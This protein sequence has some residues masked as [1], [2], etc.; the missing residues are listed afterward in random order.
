[1][2]INSYKVGAGT[3]TLGDADLA[4]AAQC[5]SAAVVPSESVK[6][7]EP[8]PVLSGEELPGASSATISARFKGKF[9]Q[10]GNTTGVVAFTYENAGELVPFTYVPNTGESASVEGFVRIVPL[11]IGADVSKTDRAEADFDWAAYAADDESGIPVPTFI[12]PGP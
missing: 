12:A 10:D 9:L 3:L 4:V 11:Q 7:S 8:I 5:R 2:T 1:M 6:S